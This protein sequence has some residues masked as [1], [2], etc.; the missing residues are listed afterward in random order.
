[1]HRFVLSLMLFSFS[2]ALTAASPDPESVNQVVARYVATL[3]AQGMAN[4]EEVE[5]VQTVVADLNGDGKAEIVLWST[6]YFGSSSSS[7]LTVFT[8][9]GRGF[10]P[11]AQSADALGQVEKIETQGTRVLVHALWPGPKDPRCCPGQK[12]TAS[13]A[14]QGDKLVAKR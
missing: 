7:Q 10:I 6:R 3:N 13:Y 9:R 5:A 4:R 14:W 11:A 8:D 1:M 2:G 12:R